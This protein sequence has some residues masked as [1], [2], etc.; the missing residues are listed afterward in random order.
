MVQKFGG[1]SVADPD[2]IRAVADHIA[3]TR[4]SGDDVVVVVSAMGKTTDDLVRL[5]NDVARPDASARAGRREMDMLLTAGERISMALLCMAVEALGVPAVSFTGSQA[6]IVTDTDH[7]RAKIL[8]VR[9][10]PHPGGAG[11]RARSRSSPG[12]RASRPRET[13]RRSAAAAPTRPPSRWPPRSAPTCARSTPTSRASTAPT[14]ASF[15]PR[16]SSRASRSTRCSRWLR[17][18]GACSRCARS[19]SRATTA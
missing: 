17:P 16:A 10:R 11:G 2:R 9:G 19:S 4:R 13:S 5:A 8:E 7:G 1:T 14:R 15:R 12:S 6:G 3:R 18:A